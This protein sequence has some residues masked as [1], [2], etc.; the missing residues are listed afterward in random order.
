[1]RDKCTPIIRRTPLKR[2]NV[3]LKRCPI[4]RVSAKQAKRVSAIA[5]LRREKVEASGPF[6]QIYSPDCTNH[7]QGIHHIKK[8]SQGGKDT[9]DNTLLACNRCQTFIEDNPEWA[10]Y[11]GFSINRKYD[12]KQ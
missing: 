11:M 3:A 10:A 9:H 12:A 4:R 6:C 5:K 7:E 8:K 2:S 1:M